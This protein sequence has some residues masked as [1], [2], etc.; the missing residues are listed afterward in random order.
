MKPLRLLALASVLAVAA[1]TSSP[2][3]SADSAAPSFDG[4]NMIGGGNY[5]GDPDGPGT[6]GSGNSSDDG[7]ASLGSGNNTASDTTGR[8]GGSLGSGN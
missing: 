3:T 6:A 2:T 8:G 5:T 4:G 1:C 7:G